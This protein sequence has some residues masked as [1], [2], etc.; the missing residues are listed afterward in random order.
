M[1]ESDTRQ[2]EKDF[3][4]RARFTGWAH[5]EKSKKDFFQK[6]L[7]EARA[8]RQKKGRQKARVETGEKNR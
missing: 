4:A 6:I 5:G 3:T 8:R 7:R 2:S 1:S